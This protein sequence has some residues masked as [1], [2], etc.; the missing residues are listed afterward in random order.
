MSSA[1]LAP[2]E[3]WM[4]AKDG[5]EIYSQLWDPPNYHDEGTAPV[6]AT[7]VLVH[8]VGEHV[9]RYQNLL[10]FLAQNGIRVCAFDQRGF[11]RTGRRG[12]ILGFNDG[13]KTTM[14]DI[15]FFEELVALEGKPHFIYGHSMG[16]GLVLKYA[17][18]NPQRLKGV[19]SSAPL[20]GL[21]KATSVSPIEYHASVV[22]S[23]V[24][25]TAVLYK[26][27]DPNLLAMDKAVGAAYMADPNVHPYIALGTAADVVLNGKWLSSQG[28]TKFPEKV[29]LLLTHG[30]A[31]LITCPITS[32]SFVSNCSSED[33]T[34]HSF[35]GG[36]HEVHFDSGKEKMHSLLLEWI[37]TRV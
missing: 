9:G 6:V 11:G 37:R 28:A 21:G 13:I 8:G 16:G 20:I 32:K 36:Y 19:I 25:K 17:I 27:V 15:A 4:S 22:L 10:R 33:K 7:M 24:L 34:F 14:S 3:M 1:A 23:K 12:G 2:T 35:D 29:A 18:E 5:H 30:S 31:D 26:P